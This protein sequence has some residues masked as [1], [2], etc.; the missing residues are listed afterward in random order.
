MWFVV[1]IRKRERLVA[2]PLSISRWNGPL[3]PLHSRSATFLRAPFT[4]SNTSLC[5]VLW[6]FVMDQDN[7]H[8]E[9]CDWKMEW[10][11]TPI[12]LLSLLRSSS[13]RCQ[14]YNFTQFS[15]AVKVVTANNPIGWFFMLTL[16]SHSGR[17][18]RQFCNSEWA[19][20]HCSRWQ[21]IID[22][23]TLLDARCWCLFE[24][25]D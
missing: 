5:C 16:S 18:S 7:C 15:P 20:R 23:I 3:R 25:R 2:A 22:I 11:T 10:K 14:R 1:T 24:A 19:H 4:H 9:W 12:T 21:L 6:V 17:H 13:F 8:D